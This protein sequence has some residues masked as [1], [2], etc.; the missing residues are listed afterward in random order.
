LREAKVTR[1]SSNRQAGTILVKAVFSRI[2]QREKVLL[3]NDYWLPE[4][5]SLARYR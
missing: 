2:F 4:L 3:F 1:T 5:L